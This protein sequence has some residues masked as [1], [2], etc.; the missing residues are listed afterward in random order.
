MVSFKCSVFQIAVKGRMPTRSF[1]GSIDASLPTSSHIYRLVCPVRWPIFLGFDRGPLS[2]LEQRVLQN[3]LIKSLC[4]SP[5]GLTACSVTYPLD[6][7]R[8][9]LAFQ[10]ADE[11]LYL[12]IRH[13]IREISSCEGGYVAL[14]RGFCTQSL[15]MLPTVG[16]LGFKGLLS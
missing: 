6:T 1:E 16:K 5:E 8:C 4:L 15:A 11:R 3:C 14:Y 7:V 10:V 9:R 2:H 13:A 12:G